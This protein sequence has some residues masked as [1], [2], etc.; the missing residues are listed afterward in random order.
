MVVRGV[1]RQNM[2]HRGV[3]PNAAKSV[4]VLLGL[5]AS[6]D[7]RHAVDPYP[8]G[9]GDH[10]AFGRAWLQGCRV[11]ATGRSESPDSWTVEQH[12]L[13]G[14]PSRLLRLRRHPSAPSYSIFETGCRVVHFRKYQLS[15]CRSKRGILK[16]CTRLE[17]RDDFFRLLLA[18]L[19]W[20]FT[21]LRSD[22]CPYYY[23]KKASI[24]MLRPELVVG[25]EL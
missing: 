6:L 10:A 25:Y 13:D 2:A 17:S 22:N 16:R 11:S 19:K 5:W 24:N 14:R 21:I 15:K 4:H 7:E 23:T 3:S 8:L 20:N 12:Y 1:R 9:V 18:L